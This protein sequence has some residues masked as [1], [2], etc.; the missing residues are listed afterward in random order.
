MNMACL[1]LN[2]RAIELY[3]E[4]LH[5]AELVSFSLSKEGSPMADSKQPSPGQAQNQ[6]DNDKATRPTDL[7]VSDDSSTDEISASINVVSTGEERRQRHQG[8]GDDNGLTSSERNHGNAIEGFDDEET[9]RDELRPKDGS[10]GVAA[11]TGSD[12]DDED[13]LPTGLPK[14]PGFEDYNPGARPHTRADDRG[15]DTNAA[16]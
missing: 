11:G 15:R 16:P 9:L 14:K 13:V 6:L 8:S 3:T 4:Q 10:V 12:A 1:L 2:V 7:G 5:V